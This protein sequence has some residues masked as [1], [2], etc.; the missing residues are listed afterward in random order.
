MLKLERKLFDELEGYKTYT[1]D[2]MLDGKKIGRADIIVA[3]EEKTDE[4]YLEWIG[5]DEEYRG[6]GFGTEA[7]MMLVEEFK[8]LYFAACDE[9]NAKFYSRIGEEYNGENDQVDQGY[10]IYFIEK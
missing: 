10:G 3:P 1:N 8:F 6:Q 4:V 9:Q 5:I 7:I 2:I